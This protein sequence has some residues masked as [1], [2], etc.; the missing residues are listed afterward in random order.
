MVYK[1]VLHYFAEG[2]ASLLPNGGEREG[3][4][5]NNGLFYC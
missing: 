5:D 1:Y 4:E 3:R 2:S